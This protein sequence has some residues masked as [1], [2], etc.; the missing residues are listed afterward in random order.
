MSS[1]CSGFPSTCPTASPSTNP[2]QGATSCV[3]YKQ[4]PGGNAYRSPYMGKTELAAIFGTGDSSGTSVRTGEKHLGCSLLRASAIPGRPELHFNAGA[5]LTDCI[6]PPPK[7]CCTH[8][9]CSPVPRPQNSPA[10]FPCL[11][12]RS[13]P[14]RAGPSHAR[15]TPR[16]PCR[17]PA[18]SQPAPRRG[19][20]S[21]FYFLV[22][23]YKLS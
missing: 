10:V 9:V 3:F 12:A 21:A 22:L 17:P 14:S 23:L 16:P 19:W 13:C 6:L 7:L 2:D 15:R 11:H 20:R 4:V 8:L 18:T 5:T 1:T